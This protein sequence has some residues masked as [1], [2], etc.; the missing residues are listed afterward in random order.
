[1]VAPSVSMAG[2]DMSAR[3]AGRRVA[4]VA[5]QRTRCSKSK[6]RNKDTIEVGLLS[7]VLG[8][9]HGSV[10]FGWK[11]GRLSAAKHAHSACNGRA[12]AKVRVAR[13]SLLRGTARQHRTGPSWASND[14]PLKDLS[15]TRALKHLAP[16]ATDYWAAP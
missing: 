8:G 10:V 7:L 16:L 6:G 3:T 13:Q 15:N 11:H 9:K 14:A 1:V 4:V 12:A 2:S 5:L